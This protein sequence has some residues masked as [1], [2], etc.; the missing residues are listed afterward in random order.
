M[1][2]KVKLSKNEIGN[3]CRIFFQDQN[4][5]IVSIFIIQKGID[6]RLISGTEKKFHRSRQYKMY[7]AC[8]TEFNLPLSIPIFFTDHKVIGAFVA[9][10][11]RWN[12]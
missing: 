8:V 1:C 10:Q 5:R 12:Q 11:G 4:S 9:L 2:C 7:G 3:K 6:V